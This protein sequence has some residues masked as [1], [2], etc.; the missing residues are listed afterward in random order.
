MSWQDYQAYHVHFSSAHSRIRCGGR[1]PR[2][3]PVRSSQAMP[4]MDAVGEEVTMP[5]RVE[6]IRPVEERYVEILSPRARELL[7]RLH[8]ALADRPPAAPPPPPPPPAA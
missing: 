3:V 8:D 1:G 5:E 7:V 2:T 4:R 6:I